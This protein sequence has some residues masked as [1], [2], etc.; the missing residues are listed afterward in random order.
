MRS[1]MLS[2][3]GLC[4]L[5]IGCTFTPHTQKQAQLPLP[6]YLGPDFT[7]NW[8]DEEEA[9]QADMHR[10]APFSFTNQEGEAISN[11]TVAGKIYVAD[12]F[13]TFCPGICPRLTSNMAIL[14]DTFLTDP[15]VLF[16]S[17]TVTPWMDSVSV[18]KRYAE[19]HGVESGK[20][21][22]LT[23]DKKEIYDLARRSYF[24]DEDIGFQRNE[25]D[26]LHTEN[27]LLIDQKGRIRGVYNGTLPLEMKNLVDDPAYAE[28]LERLRGRTDELRDLYG[29]PYVPHE[30]EPAMLP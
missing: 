29:G 13:F 12:F 30:G 16:L 20:W 1:R 28:E 23:G 21:H 6:Y 26:F 22:L 9:N 19:L 27:F 15:D 14:Q 17:H 25:N 11:Q 7:P 8:L 24:A 4:L 5:G 2:I 18:L 3:L 10:I